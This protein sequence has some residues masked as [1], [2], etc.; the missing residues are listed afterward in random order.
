MPRRRL[1]RLCLHRRWRRRM[2]SSKSESIW[3]VRA[4]DKLDLGRD[5]GSAGYDGNDLAVF[6]ANPA[7][8]YAADDALLPPYVA[9]EQLSVGVKASKLRAGASAARRAVVL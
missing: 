8:E 2:V 3:I 4:E 1:H 5:V 6:N 7:F 9:F